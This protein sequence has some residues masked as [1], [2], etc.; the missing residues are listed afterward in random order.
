MKAIALVPLI[1]S[2]VSLLF[3]FNGYKNRPDREN[4]LF[5]LCLLVIAAIN[6]VFFNILQSDLEAIIRF[7]VMVLPVWVLILPVFFHYVVA[8][9]GDEK[10]TLFRYAI[11]AVYVLSILA[12][13][14]EY[15]FISFALEHVAFDGEGNFRVP[16][17]TVWF[18]IPR[19]FAIV[20]NLAIVVLGVRYYRRSPVQGKRGLVKYVV[21]AAL[22]LIITNNASFLLGSSRFEVFFMQFIVLM[23]P[24]IYFGYAHNRSTLRTKVI[25]LLFREVVMLGDDI[26][27]AL[28]HRKVIIFANAHLFEALGRPESE[29]IGRDIA[30]FLEVDTEFHLQENDVNQFNITLRGNDGTSRRFVVRVLNLKDRRGRIIYTVIAGQNPRREEAEDFL[31]ICSYCKNVKISGLRW[32]RFE[33][34]LADHYNLEFTHGICPDCYKIIMHK[35]T[36]ENS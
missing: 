22:L 33:E 29:V 9:T 24:V 5:F 4:F 7:W 27:L 11:A 19:V 36:R 1:F 21:M 17:G 25:D 12:L 30:A 13:V 2:I 28:D 32:V 14:S 3:G 26:F 16:T 23:M 20:V 15:R 6:F 34:Y 35:F 31:Q 10:R 8:F 18:Y